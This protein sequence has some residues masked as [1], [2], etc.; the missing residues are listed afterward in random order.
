MYFLMAFVVL[1]FGFALAGGSL[2]A[3]FKTPSGKDA[4]GGYGF[5][6]VIV[7][8]LTLG[9]AVGMVAIGFHAGLVK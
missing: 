2:I 7:T 6:S 5:M 1:A 9:A 4:K 3:S 8:I